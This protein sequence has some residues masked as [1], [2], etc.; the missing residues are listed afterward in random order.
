[1]QFDEAR[2][3]LDEFTAWI[4]TRR[5]LLEEHGFSVTATQFGQDKPGVRVDL[6]S[7]SWQARIVLWATG[8]CEL[9]K[10]NVQ[11]DESVS[12]H[13]DISSPKEFGQNFSPFLSDLLGVDP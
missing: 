7:A 8:E 3:M 4:G 6:E 2:S 9:D 11:S 13:C 10:I 1:E 5:A 12:K